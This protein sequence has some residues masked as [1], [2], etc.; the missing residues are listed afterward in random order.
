MTFRE[1]L[2]NEGKMKDAMLHLR[3]QGMPRGKV[4]H[5]QRVARAVRGSGAGKEATMAA[6]FH[7]YLERGGDIETA[8]M[9]FKLSPLATNVILHLSDPEKSDTDESPNGPLAHI[10]AILGSNK[11]PLEE[12]RIVA[13]IKI[14]DRLDNLMR[15]G[16][17]PSKGYIRKSEEL[18]SYLFDFYYNSFGKDNTIKN[19]H[20]Q[21]RDLNDS[22]SLKRQFEIPKWKQ[23]KA[24]RDLRI[25]SSAAM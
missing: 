7:D 10:Q 4:S 21:Y 6:A 15:R 11:I 20:R 24:Q 2:M 14:A 12:R 13:I 19:L 22:L 5:S 8:Q 17:K 9:K 25:A 23:W 1:F 16:R 3:K 18:L